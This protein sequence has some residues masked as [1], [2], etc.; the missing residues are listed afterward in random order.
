M[1]R[2]DVDAMLAEL[3]PQQLGE[4]MAAID[5]VGLDDSWLQAGTISAAIHNSVLRAMAGFTK[6]RKV[7]RKSVAK[8]TD[9]IPL[10]GRKRTEIKAQSAAQMKAA[11]EGTRRG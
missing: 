11:I 4:W 9:Y 3:T 1:G 2:V 10:V 6:S 7:D 5:F 8:A